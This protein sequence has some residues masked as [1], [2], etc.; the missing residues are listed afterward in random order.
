MKV[1]RLI[2]LLA[3]ATMTVRADVKVGDSLEQVLSAMGEPRGEIKAGTY[4]LLYFER[5]RVELRNGKVSK[6]DLV[7]EAQ[8][9]KIRLSREKQQAEAAQM[10]AEARTKRIVE[11]MA[12]R[13]SK[14]AETA[15]MNAPASERVAYWQSFKKLYPEVPLGAEYTTALADLEKD[16]AVQR[17]ASAQ[18]RQLDSLEQRVAD[19]ED[20]AKRAEPRRNSITI[21][22]D[23]PAVYGYGYPYVTYNPWINT[24][25]RAQPAKSYAPFCTTY[26]PATVL[27]PFSYESVSPRYLVTPFTGGGIS[28]SINAR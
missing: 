11:G 23:S 15:F 28:F 14:L 2:L 19:A 21:Y 18:Q 3:V 13:K 16:L 20:R 27:S 8:Q 9:E 22:D 26:P 10:A 12:L 6:M 7:S 24:P 25:Q 17:I 5:G 4:Q 1:A